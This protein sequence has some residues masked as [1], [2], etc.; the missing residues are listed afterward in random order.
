MTGDRNNV[1]S[2]LRVLPCLLKTM[3]VVMWEI[4]PHDMCAQHRLKSACDS[5]QSDQSLY[6]PH[7]KTT[8]NK[9]TNKKETNKPKKTKNKKT[10]FAPLA[11]QNAPREDSDQTVRMRRLIWIFT[12]RTCRKVCFLTL[13]RVYVCSK[14]KVKIRRKCYNHETKPSPLLKP[15]RWGTKN[16]KQTPSMKLPTHKQRRTARLT[17]S[18]DK[19]KE[20]RQYYTKINFNK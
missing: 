7:K 2:T 19:P 15:E 14:T 11:I 17:C 1:T 18:S 12:V 13:R 16:E 8:K 6:C 3:W 10:N 20:N 5:A 4:V 9:Q